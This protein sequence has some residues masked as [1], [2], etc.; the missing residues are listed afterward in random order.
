MNTETAIHQAIL[1]AL[2][3]R[4]HPIGV[5]YRQNAGR[6][7]NDRGAWVYLGPT[8]ISDIVGL[9]LGRAI[10]IEVKTATGRQRPEQKAFQA[11]VERAG[12]IYILARSPGEAV[13]AV[14]SAV[15]PSAHAQMELMSQVEAARLAL[16]AAGPTDGKSGVGG[17]ARSAPTTA[18]AGMATDPLPKK[19]RTARRR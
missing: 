12:G 19:A 14:L 2:S 17:R 16:K 3:Q 6:V 5:F 4:F 13:D 18:P 7:R 9:L 1:L 10:Y 15:A 11:A 8:G